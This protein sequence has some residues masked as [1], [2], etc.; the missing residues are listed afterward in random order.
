MVDPVSLG[1][2]LGIG[3]V[4]AVVIGLLSWRLGRYASSALVARLQ[5]DAMTLRTQLDERERAWDLQRKQIEADE[6]RLAREF[7]NLGNRVLDESTRKFLEQASRTILPVASQLKVQLDGQ[8]GTHKESISGVVKPLETAL[9]EMRELV[10]RIE[11]ARKTD[12]G[13]LDKQLQLLATNTDALRKE[14]SAIS[15]ALRNSQV[16]GSWG[17]VALRNLIEIA[18]MTEHCD[19]ETQVSLGTIEER[20]RPDVVIKLP[21]GR[22]IPVDSKMSSAAYLRALEAPDDAS[23]EEALTEHASQVLARVRELTSKEYWEKLREIGQVPEFV[24]MFIP[25]DNLFAA[26]LS[27]DPT[28]FER[29]AIGKVMLSSPTVLLPLLR[30]VELGWRQASLLKNVDEIRVQARELHD[31]LVTMT[32]HIQNVGS[33]LDGAVAAYNSFI[34]SYESRVLTKAREFKSLGVEGTK[35]LPEAVHPIE[36]SARKVVAGAEQTESPKDVESAT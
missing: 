3:A 6:A 17:E 14:A 1:I 34:G 16:K 28:L 21:S 8:L 32:G 36:R 35:A 23:R 4:V 10:E 29:A 24:V 12:Y 13:G 15:G 19:F 33:K 7:E 31:R 26:A 25:G 9:K 30:V 18:G 27:K 5:S 2:G 20:V 22:V 11:A